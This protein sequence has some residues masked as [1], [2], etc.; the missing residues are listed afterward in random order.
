MK[1]HVEVFLIARK[2]TS[3]AITGPYAKKCQSHST[4]IWEDKKRGGGVRVARE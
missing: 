4:S 1:G 3:E 2:G